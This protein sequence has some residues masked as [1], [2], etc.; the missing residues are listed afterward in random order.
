M[1]GMSPERFKSALQFMEQIKQ[2]AGAPAPQ[3]ERLERALRISGNLEVPTDKPERQNPTTVYMPGLT[4]EPFPDPSQLECVG[5]LEEAYPKIRQELLDLLEDQ[6]E[7]SLHRQ[8]GDLIHQGT[9]REY[10]FFYK[11]RLYSEH[12]DRCPHTAVALRSIPD[13]T[14]FGSAKFLLTTPGTHIETHCG[15]N[16]L[17]LRCHLGLVIPEGNEIR[18]A[19]EARSWQEG[20]CLVIDDSFD[21]EVWNRG[22]GV[23]ALLNVDVWHPD[24][25]QIER[26]ILLELIGKFQGVKTQ[27]A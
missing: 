20:K 22:D 2:S 13:L 23:R 15:P 5:I 21:H 19:T 9:W 7:I 4:A 18:V 11:G 8:S 27:V 6:E 24:I 10:L 17:R 25:T 14:P 16:N 1:K 3:L 26:R 12:L